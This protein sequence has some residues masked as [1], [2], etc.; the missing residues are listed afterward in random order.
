MP[1]QIMLVMLMAACVAG[2]L[3][4]GIYRLAW[5]KRPISP[6]SPAPAGVPLRHWHDRLPIVGWW[7]LRREQGVHGRGFW[8]RPALIE[9]SFIVGVGALY[10]FELGGGLLP[11]G[12]LVPPGDVLRW[13]F[14]NHACLLAL[15]VVATFIDLDEKTIPDEI[16]VTGT[17]AAVL[18]AGTR[19]DVALPAWTTDAP[20]IPISP[21]RMSTPDAWRAALDG[22]V[23]W[24]LAI[25]C[26]LGWWYALLPKT[27]WYRGGAGKFLRYLATS[28]IRNRFSPRISALAVAAAAA[29]TLFWWRGGA[30]WQAVLSAW[31]GMAVAGLVVWLVRIVGSAA[32]GQEAMGFG[33]VTLLGM[34]GAFLGWQPALLVFF[35]APFSGVVLAVCQRLLTGRRDIAYGPFL[36]FAA[37]LLI[38]GWADVWPGWGLPVFQLGWLVPVVLMF[39]LML[40]GGLLWFVQRIKSVV[41]RGPSGRA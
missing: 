28:L 22:H 2:Q 15:M 16:T 7:F 20:P 18:L 17:L 38:V 39:S 4:R 3:N 14:F 13:Q 36:C 23:G 34:I 31:V 40:L 9:L 37:L 19:P 10:A 21:L 6:W 32:L 5:H 26:I 1:L 30:A 41:I 11:I 35:F 8:I 12:A 29:T 27:L 33:D 25:S 24:W